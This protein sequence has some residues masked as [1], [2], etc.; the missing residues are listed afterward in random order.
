MRLI[1]SGK[2]IYS[3]KS[4]DLIYRIF[5]YKNKN[6]YYDTSYTMGRFSC[7][8]KIISNENGKLMYLI[9]NDGGIKKIK[10]NEN[11]ASEWYYSKDHLFSKNWV[12]FK[13]WL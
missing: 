8:I 9:N 4:G 10:F 5:P 3:F 13:N 6:D 1:P 11:K 2:N 7:P 12:K